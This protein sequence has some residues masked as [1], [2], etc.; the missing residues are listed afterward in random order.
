MS[1]L[2]VLETGIIAETKI[3]KTRQTQMS[4]WVFDTANSCGNIVQP[5][6]SRFAVLEIPGYNFEEFRDIVVYRL[7]A[8]NVDE[9]TAI[10]IAKEV[11]G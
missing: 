8:Q 9:T 6:M 7:K 5:L 11:F 2:N 4:A 3:N 1:L 10:A